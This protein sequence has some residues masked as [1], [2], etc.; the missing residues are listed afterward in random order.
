M[1][2]I[3][4]AK[5]AFSVGVVM[6][7]WHAIWVGLVAL[8]SAAEVMNFILELHFLK[9]HVEIMP[10]AVSTAL[11]LIS[12]TFCVGALFGAIFAIVWNWLTV[13]SAPEWARDTDRSQAT[14]N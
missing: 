4:I 2:H 6:A 5:A 11:A 12:L 1:R 3:G 7:A 9:M 10:Y 8:G 14:M 13:A